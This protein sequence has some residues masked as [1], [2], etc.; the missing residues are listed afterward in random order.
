[1]VRDHLADVHEVDVVG[2]EHRDQ[3]RLREL[4]QVDVLV[5]RIGGALVPL[6]ALAHLGGDR[7][8]ELAGEDLGE[9]P[10]VSHVLEQGLALELGEDVDRVDPGIDEV[11]EDEVDDAVLAGERDSGL[12][13]L[14][15]EREEAGALPPGQN[16]A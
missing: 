9:L 16:E 7:N 14:L 3:L 10:R 12:G 13:P 1:M 15:G 5:D 6:L 4:D 2:A 11:A 8:D